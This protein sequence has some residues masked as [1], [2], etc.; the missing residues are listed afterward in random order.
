M[1]GRTWAFAT[2]GTTGQPV[3]WHRTPGQIAAEAALLADLCQAREGGVD[4]VVSFAPLRHLYGHLMGIAVPTTL[5]VPCRLVSV[6]APLRWAFA[7]LRRPLVAA[8]PA[9]IA[10]LQH[11]VGLLR[12]LDEIVL[13]HGSA[14]LTPA[15]ATLLGDLAGRARLVDLF[16][17]TETGLVGYRRSPD[18]AWTPAP[19]VTLAEE[20][21]TGR[22]IVHGPRIA[23][24]PGS[25]ARTSAVLED[26]VSVNPDGTFCW[27][28]RSNRLLKINGRRVHLDQVEAALHSRVPGATVRC[29]PAADPRR[30]EWFDVHVAGADPAEVADVERACRSLPAWQRPRTV[31][32]A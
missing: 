7:G 32:A 2:S 9:A 5:G 12:G 31:R 20:P 11:S 26:L 25:P 1:D 14:V 13:V 16:G 27:S 23:T 30:G 22:L 29:Q 4:G 3:V 17:S 18:A 19:D 28:G 15:T 24:R 21:G 6:T 10:S 8:M